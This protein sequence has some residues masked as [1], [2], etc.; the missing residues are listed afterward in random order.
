VTGPLQQNIQAIDYLEELPVKFG[1][2]CR[3]KG[4]EIQIVGNESAVEEAY[5][6]FSSIQ[7][8]VIGQ[9]KTILI[10]CIHYPEKSAHYGLY[11]CTLNQYRHKSFV[12]TNELETNDLNVI[13]PVFID[14]TTQEYGRPK[15]LLERQVAEKAQ[16]QH[17]LNTVEQLNVVMTRVAS[18][19]E[20]SQ[21]S[22]G[23]DR[24]FVNVYGNS[25]YNTY[26]KK[27]LH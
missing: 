21:S 26:Q 4:R 20:S 13:L 8:T 18:M 1:V 6:A 5:N 25:N 23:E 17:K 14:K 16:M 27:D 2:E 19:S 7:R 9:S 10:P 22:W 24:D 3:L 11:F 15:D 12:Y